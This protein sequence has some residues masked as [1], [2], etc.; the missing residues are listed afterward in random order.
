M[1]SAESPPSPAPP[2]SPASAARPARIRW[3]G[4]TDRGR[5]RAN[6]EDAFLALTF[7]GREVRYL[8]KTGESVIDGRE[9]I[10]AVSDG[11]GGANSGEIASRMAIDRITHL[12][13]Q[14]PVPRSGDEH[15]ARSA[16]LT[17]LFASIHKDLLAL[18]SSYEECAG[19]GATLSLCWVTARA[20]HFAHVGDSRLYA[21][22]LGG[23]LRQLT[24]DHNHVGWLLRQGRINEREARSHPLRHSLHR[25]MGAGLR[26]AEP[27][28]G[29]CP[30]GVGDRFLLCTD[31]V[32]DGLWDRHLDELARDD[33]SLPAG[34][35]PAQRIVREAVEKSGRDNATALIFE[36]LDGPTPAES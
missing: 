30:V 2:E 32:I 14:N 12:L 25:A 28:L 21:L 26:E 31:G 1:S 17:R 22:P 7:D 8:G 19:M 23:P 4:L 27:D 6:N 10:F 33:A 3:S 18:G 24:A 11:M 5:V 16:I 13:P 36:F 9:F 20:V 34:E 35:S 29:S 15:A